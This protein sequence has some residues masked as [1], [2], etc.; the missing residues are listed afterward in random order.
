MEMKEVLVQGTM[1][2]QLIQVTF[3]VYEVC[4]CVCMRE[5]NLHVCGERMVTVEGTGD[6][7]ELFCIAWHTMCAMQCCFVGWHTVCTVH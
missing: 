7:Y 5:C 2:S 3:A 4:V 6:S 1:V